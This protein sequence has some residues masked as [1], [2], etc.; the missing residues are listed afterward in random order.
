MYNNTY[1]YKK[2]KRIF[3]QNKC[4]EIERLNTNDP[5]AFWREIQQLGP[6]STSNIPMVG[7]LGYFSIFSQPF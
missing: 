2:E 1:R 6:K 4:D 3:Q 7:C 5:R